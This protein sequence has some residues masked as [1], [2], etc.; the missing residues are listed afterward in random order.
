MK[1]QFPAAA[2]GLIQLNLNALLS[3]FATRG[4]D[5]HSEG[6]SKF[7]SPLS[8]DLIWDTQFCHLTCDFCVCFIWRGWEVGELEVTSPFPPLVSATVPLIRYRQRLIRDISPRYKSC[9]V[10]HL[11]NESLPFK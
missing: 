8:T 11:T 7:F 10:S 6:C 9:P 5:A 2:A 4:P 3:A 1:C